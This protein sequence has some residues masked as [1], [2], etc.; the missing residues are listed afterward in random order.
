[1]TAPVLTEVDG[2]VLAITLDRPD[3]RNAIDSTM[4]EAI[5]AAIDR[6]DGERE[7]RVAVLAANGPAFCAGLDLKAFALGDRGRSEARGFGGITARP[8]RKPVVVAVEGPALGGGF[9]IVLACDLIVASSNARF[10]LPEA[11]RG[12]LATA[13]GLLRLPRRIPHHRAMEMVLVGKPMS[14]EEAYALGLVNRL[15]APG[16]ARAAALELA[17]AIAANA[18]LAV[19][20]AKQVILESPEWPR[21]EAFARQEQIAAPIRASKDAAE[22][23]RA[24]VEKRTPSW[25]GE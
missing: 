6:L 2:A 7:L 10:G 25:R 9:E 11:T 24:F 15:V 5:C 12:Q 1:M 8:P 4:A 20:G 13:G 14:A 18:P 22:G 17:R 16:E 23:A 3:K 19:A 21:E